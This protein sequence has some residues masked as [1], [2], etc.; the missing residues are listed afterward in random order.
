MIESTFDYIGGYGPLILFLI[1]IKLLWTK[2]IFL[3]YYSYGFFLDI[4]L[5]LI[6]V[7]IIAF[8]INKFYFF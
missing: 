4:I 5:N 8:L 3:A 2:P 6:L 1:S 7:G